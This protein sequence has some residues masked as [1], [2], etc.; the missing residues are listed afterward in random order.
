MF[1]ATHD[2]TIRLEAAAATLAPPARDSFHLI[3]TT[4][5]WAPKSGGVNA[6]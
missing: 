2:N 1:D 6:T 4:M 3:D 5:M